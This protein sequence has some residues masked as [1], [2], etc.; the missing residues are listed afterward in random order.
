[1]LSQEFPS[2]ILL[3]CLTICKPELCQLTSTLQYPS[4]KADV[5]TEHLKHLFSL[6]L[7]YSTYGTLSEKQY[8][9]KFV[10]TLF[11]LKQCDLPKNSVLY[12]VS[13]IQQ[14]KLFNIIVTLYKILLAVQ[15]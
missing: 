6:V 4:V 1:M 11:H 5:F 9:L 3:V 8:F 7:R 10:V 12:L 13:Y 2:G 15:S 14:I